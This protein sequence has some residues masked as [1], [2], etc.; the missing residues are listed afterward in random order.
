M[1]KNVVYIQNTVNIHSIENKFSFN[2]KFLFLFF[3]DN[4]GVLHM[5]KFKSIYF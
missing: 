1:L 3:L 4:F 5:L 2:N